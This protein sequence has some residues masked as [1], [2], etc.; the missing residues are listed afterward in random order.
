MNY[1]D[2]NIYHIENEN[3]IETA[4]G[5]MLEDSIMD[6]LDLLVS[7]SQKNVDEKDSSYK[8]SGQECYDKIVKLVEE[9]GTSAEVVME[10]NNLIREKME[11]N[12]PR[13]IQEF[14]HKYDKVFK[15]IIFVS[16]NGLHKC[17]TL[18]TT[19]DYSIDIRKSE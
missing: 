1:F 5:K 17:K 9:T 8:T 12:I 15:V 7:R 10:N 19:G 2:Y 3:V 14:N 18:Q 16:G 13:S 4:D 11:R 6:V